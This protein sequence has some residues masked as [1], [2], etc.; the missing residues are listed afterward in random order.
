MAGEPDKVD[1]KKLLEK[2][3]ERAKEQNGLPARGAFI[4]EEFVRE[5]FTLEN[6]KEQLK[7]DVDTQSYSTYN[8]RQLAQ[9]IKD[10]GKKL[11]AVL[12]LLDQSP[13][14]RPL[15]ERT[16][17]VTDSF[18]FETPRSGFASLPCPMEKLKSIKHLADIADDFY[19]KQFVFPP[20]LTADETQDFHPRF[21]MFP[22]SSKPQR[23]NNGAYGE[24]YAVNL[25]KGYLEPHTNITEESTKVLN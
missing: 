15:F 12:I 5:L 25:P 23:L 6:I 11:Y 17:Q 10:K 20:S 16:P 18:L 13:L 9:F 2:Q 8:I 3:M 22:F 21:F 14:I 24:V 1:L 19:Q 4:T 7:D